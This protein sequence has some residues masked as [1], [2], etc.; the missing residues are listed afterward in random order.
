[1][2]ALPKL[3]L[4]R[5]QNI[6]V[7]GAFKL[8]DALAHLGLM[9]SRLLLMVQAAV[10]DGAFFDPVSPFDD[11]GVAPEVGIGG[12]YVA[13]AFMIALVVAMLDEGINLV[14]QVARQNVIFQQHA[15][16]QGLVPTPDLALGL[17]MVRCATNMIHALVIEPFGQIAGYVRRPIAAEQPR[18]VFNMNFTAARCLQRQGQRLGHIVGP[19]GGAQLPGDDVARI[20]V[21]NGR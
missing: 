14:F 20:V 5:R 9:L 19:H 15:V 1:M 17:G 16:L 8:T 2:S 4:V 18:L 7:N 21:Q 12:R 3:L 13:E 11:G 6:W 10:L